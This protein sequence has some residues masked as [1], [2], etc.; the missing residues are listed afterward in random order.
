MIYYF[1]KEGEPPNEEKYIDA[2]LISGF[3]ASIS[4][5]WVPP[6]GAALGCQAETGTGAAMGAAFAC[7]L[8]GGDDIKI[9]NAYILALKNSLRLVCDPVA[10]RVNTPCI[11]RN[12]FKAIEAINAA[13][14]SLSGVESFISGDEILLAMREIGLDMQSKYRET[15]EGGLA[16]TPT[17]LKEKYLNRPNYCYQL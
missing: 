16:K 12:G 13:F 2:L 1:S 17:G 3:L 6:S 7:Y 11:K 15:S 5:N 8:L 10:G 9:L 14:L 4:S